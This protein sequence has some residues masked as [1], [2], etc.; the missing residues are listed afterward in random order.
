MKTQDPY[1]EPAGT[2]ASIPFKN[3][4]RVK[5]PPSQSGNSTR[6]Q[7]TQNGFF[8][9]VLLGGNSWPHNKAG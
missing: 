1:R 2:E 3:C 9:T 4:I 7:V 5:M 6:H 8:V